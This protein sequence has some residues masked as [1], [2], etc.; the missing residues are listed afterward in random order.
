MPL[1]NPDIIGTDDRA[2][3]EGLV[4]SRSTGADLVILGFSPDRLRELGPALFLR[5][6]TLDDCLLVSAHQRILIE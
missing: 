1:E 6:P 3:F 2:N 4:E 5:H